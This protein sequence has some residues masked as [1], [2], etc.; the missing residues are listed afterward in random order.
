[1]AAHSTARA[2]PNP[3]PH[4]SSHPHSSYRPQSSHHAHVSILGSKI[5]TKMYATQAQ[6]CVNGRAAC[7]NLEDCGLDGF[8]GK[9]SDTK[10]KHMTV[11]FRSRPKWTSKEIETI[12]RDCDHWKASNGC[13]GASG[14]V[15]FTLTSWGSGTS[16]LIHG[17]LH[18]LCLYLREQQARRVP[19]EDQ[20]QPHVA[21]FTRK[22][23]RRR[24]KTKMSTTKAMAVT[25]QTD[26]GGTTR[27]ISSGAAQMV[28][29][30]C[31]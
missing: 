9:P 11:V 23:N 26:R 3:G 13:A 7:V 18:D 28:N 31:T 30:T 4:Y 27:K 15:A 6:I 22:N 29:D 2:H 14:R 1:M 10:H 16:C 17:P 21:L 20:R 25:K 12:Q 8:D 24:G 5:P 19:I